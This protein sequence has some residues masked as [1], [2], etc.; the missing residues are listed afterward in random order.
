MQ[1][2][3]LYIIYFIQ[4]IN[5][6]FSVGFIVATC[7]ATTQIFYVIPDGNSTNKSCPSYP[8]ATLRQYLMDNGT[9]AVISNV[10]YRF[11][12]GQYYIT[13]NMK[14][15][16]LSNFSFI[17]ITDNHLSPVEFICWPSFYIGIFY[18]H[19]VTITNVVFNQCKGDLRTLKEFY[20]PSAGFA[21]LAFVWCYNCKI[22]DVS[23]LG[24][25]FICID[26][27]GES[28]LSNINIDIYITE[29]VTFDSCS[30]KL[31][32]TF[33]DA[34]I[35]YNKNV[36]TINQVDISGG[37]SGICRFHS[38]VAIQLLQSQYGVIAKLYNSWF[39]NM[40]RAAL[41][42]RTELSNNTVLVKN[43]TF[44]HIQHNP[45]YTYPMVAVLISNMNTKL[46]LKNCKFK[47]NT[48]VAYLIGIRVHPLNGI[49]VNPTN[50]SIV[51]FESVNNNNGNI[52][53]LF[54]DNTCVANIF[55]NGN[56]NV[57]NNT[58][59]NLIFMSE[60]AVHFNG[61]VTFSGNNLTHNILG[62]SSCNI[63]I[64]KIITFSSNDCNQVINFQSINY[65]KVMQHTSITFTDNTYH[66]EIIFIETEYVDEF[67]YPLCFFQYIMLANSSSVF[68][69]HYAINFNNNNNVL[70]FNNDNVINDYLSHCKWLSTA[71]FCDINP[72]EINQQIIKIDGKNWSH[73]NR[74]CYCFQNGTNDCNIDVLGPL[75]PGQTI[76][77]D[78]CIPDAKHNYFVYAETDSAALPNTAC[79]ITH[80]GVYIHEIGNYSK[81]INFT[82]SSESQEVCEL[83]L[84]L[85]P[86]VK[87][88]NA[89]YVELLPCP[90][91]FTLQNGICDCDPLLPNIIQTCNID[92]LA[93]R[94]PANTWI[95]T[96]NTQLNKTEYLISDCPLDYCLP[97]SSNVNLLHPDLQCQFNRTGVLCSKCQQ[98]LSMVFG[99]SRCLKCTNIHILIM[100]IIL[101]AGIILVVLLYILNL[102]VTNGTINGIIF[103]ANIIS[104]NDSV[105]LVNDDVFRPL[106]IFISFVN[107]NLGIETCLYD[108]MDG[109]VKIWLQL[110]FPFYLIFIG[111]SVIVASHFSYGVLRLTYTRSLP[112]LATLL[113]IT[114]CNILR[115][116]LTVLFFHSTIIHLPSGHQQLVWSFDASIPLFKLKFTLLFIT[117]LILLLL[118][119]ILVIVLLCT[120]YLSKYRYFK[121]LLDAFQDSYK[122]VYCYWTAVDIILRSSFFTLYAFQRKLRLI[123]ATIILVLFIGYY[124][125]T[126]PNKNRL[127][128]IQEMLLLVNLITIHAIS[129]QD[130]YIVFSIVTNLMISLAFFQFWIIVLYHFLTYTCHCN[131]VI[132]LQ[133]IREKCNKRKYQH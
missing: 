13:S 61:I 9:M 6:L 132:I 35:Y 67:V 70:D 73:H 24:Y 117:C 110:L 50:I 84:T 14:M 69:A 45:Q 44:E 2:N 88:S 46:T 85:R 30:T 43:C 31:L 65:V 104:I 4:V 47:S 131:V 28:Y 49:C 83:F 17:G 99:S 27:F 103:Y 120:K 102:T 36:I 19:N 96:H 122:D 116:V 12:Q 114:Y 124:G 18:S 1:D 106:Q 54:G 53:F 39:H 126:R 8:C 123:L 98:H 56:I 5:W 33:I 52:L 21:S 89:F 42:I 51:N 128:H 58:Q 91:G 78:L 16:G 48:D 3:K 15:W 74:I 101:V 23:F 22:L 10:E 34:Y 79:K 90:I 115:I 77:V 129:Y 121:A 100:L 130:S 97:H 55:I 57:L 125:Y 127:V 76:Q 75:Y 92:Q 107:L 32:I 81:R 7:T 37:P 119:V 108:G 11:L 68:P 60:M 133:T 71:A 59:K 26:L 72:G 112:V 66:S 86:Y 38:I 82:V 25:G 109:Y 113:L 87:S 80:K 40:D 105:F 118:L 93:I 94:R 62:F 64:S 29:T 63:T 95:T 20:E 41:N 111:I